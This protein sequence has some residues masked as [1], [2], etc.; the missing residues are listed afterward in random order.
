MSQEPAK[1]AAPKDDK[2]IVNLIDATLSADAKADELCFLSKKNQPKIDEFI[3]KI[4]GKYKSNSSSNC[5]RKDRILDKAARPS[6]L[7]KNDWFGVEHIRDGLRFRT[8]LDNFNDLPLLVA[9]LIASGAKIVKAETSKM[10]DPAEWG[11]RAVMYDLQLE[12]GQLVEYYITF[13]EMMDAND[14]PHHALYEK[15]RNC[16]AAEVTA[17]TVERGKDVDASNDAFD[18]ALET[19]FKRTGQTMSDIEAACKAADA[20]TD[21]LGRS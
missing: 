7:K 18:D 20:L 3:K 16:T 17:R 6:I 19:Y 11:W 2:D 1:P 14:D 10:L 9:D 21:S 4:D 8:A 15:W 13:Q 12:D 5:K